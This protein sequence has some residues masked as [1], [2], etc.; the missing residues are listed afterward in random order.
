MEINNINSLSFKTNIKVISPE[1][2]KKVSK[3]MFFNEHYQNISTWDILQDFDIYNINKFGAFLDFNNGAVRKNIVYVTT[4]GIRSCVGGIVANK[5]DSLAFH[6]CDNKENLNLLNTLEPHLNGKNAII[7]GSKPYWDKSKQL[8]RRI[9]KIFRD[10]K[11]PLTYFKRLK[12]TL[13][14]DYA[15]NSKSDELFLCVKDIQNPRVFVKNMEELNYAFDEVRIS[16][17]D[18]LDFSI[19]LKREK[20]Q[21]FKE[22]I[23]KAD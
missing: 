23:K 4:K 16:K 2:F 9:K 19:D 6:I 8:F 21:D 18:T 22:F 10:K 5:E 15:Y 7:L 3:K 20:Y 1:K 12:K 14:I 13:E 11:M 17:T